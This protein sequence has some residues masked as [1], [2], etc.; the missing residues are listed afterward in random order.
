MDE[1]IEVL[2]AALERC[3]QGPQTGP[4]VRL[5]LKALRFSGIPA[6]AIRGFWDGASGDHDIGRQQSMNAAL[7]RIVLFKQGKL[8]R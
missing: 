7:N 1:A 5:A 6:D 3:E 2:R 8:P 4:D